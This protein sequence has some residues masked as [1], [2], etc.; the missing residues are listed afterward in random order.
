MKPNSIRV[1]SI[2][3]VWSARGILVY[4]GFDSV[5]GIFYYRP[6]GGGL[7]PGETSQ[8]AAVRE[9]QEEIG[10]EITNLRLLGVLENQFRLE[11]EPR[12]EIVFVYEGRFRDE[13]AEQRDEFT[14]EEDNGQRMRAVWRGLDSFDA[15]H[16]LVPEGLR[17]LL[18]R[19]PIYHI[20]SAFAAGEAGISG[21]YVP[22]TFIID[23]FIHCS[24]VHQVAAVASRRF[25]GRTDLVLL[26]IDRTKLRCEVI[27]EN[28]EGGAELFPHVYGSLPM[29]AI[30]RIHEFRCDDAG[31]FSL[32][33][34]LKHRIL[35]QTRIRFR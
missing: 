15:K 9:I 34:T 13:Q 25:Q 24:Y 18:R 35:R 4:E 32:P 28:L 6:L 2:C 3:A 23:R 20:T 14:V 16:R 31:L 8:A 22:E 5:K 11:G 29:S 19:K 10:L 21:E 30:I 27:D 17:A 26:E 1:I 12:H 7:E 33:G